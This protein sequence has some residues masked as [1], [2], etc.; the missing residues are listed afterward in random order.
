MDSENQGFEGEVGKDEVVD[1]LNLRPE[2]PIRANKFLTSLKGTH[3][4]VFIKMIQAQAAFRAMT[5]TA[6]KRLLE[7]LK[8]KPV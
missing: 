2:S 8:N 3:D 6:W 4:E 7:D 1:A 5:P